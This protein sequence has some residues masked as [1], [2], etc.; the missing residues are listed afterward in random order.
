A[1]LSIPVLGAQ[2]PQA[3][4]GAP[5]GAPARG[6][7][8]AR[9]PQTPR[10]IRAVIVTG[11]NSFNGHVWKDTSAELKKILDASG[12]FAEVKIEPDPNFIANDEFLNYSVAVFDFRNDKPLAQEQKVEE[13]LTKFLNGANKGLVSVHWANGAFPYWPEYVNIVGR[14]Q[15]SVHDP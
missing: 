13:N 7:A 4:A 5:A 6:A 8:P 12:T 11:E 1:L 2:A 14:A 9:G 15:Q 10:V 3:P